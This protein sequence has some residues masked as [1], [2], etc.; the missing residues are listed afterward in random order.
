MRRN[1]DSLANQISRFA[2][3]VSLM[4]TEDLTPRRWG[5]KY[6]KLPSV[7]GWYIASVHSVPTIAEKKSRIWGE[8]KTKLRIVSSQRRA[9]SRMV[10]EP[11]FTADIMSISSGISR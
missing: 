4:V 3:Q 10:R 6:R 5:L 1:G 7:S 11:W 2:A 9:L 8:E